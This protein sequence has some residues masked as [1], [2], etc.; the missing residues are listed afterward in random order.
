MPRQTWT[1]FAGGDI[2]LDRG[3]YDVL[4][5]K[6][7]GADFPFDGGTA[8]ITSLVCCSS[9]GWKVPTLG[10]TGEQGRDP[11]PDLGAPTSR[12]RTSRT[13]RRTVPVPHVGDDL[14]RRPDADRRHRQGR[15]RLSWAWPTT[16]S[17]TRGRPA[18]S[19]PSRTSGSAACYGR[20]RQGHRRGP[21][22]GHPRHARRQGRDPR[23]RRDRR[24]TTRTDA[25]RPGS[26]R[27]TTKVVKADIKEAR[28]AGADVVIVF[29]H[30]GAEYDATAG[31][32]GEQEPGPEGHRCR[33]PTWSSATTPTGP[34]RWRS[35]RASRSGTR[36]ATSSS[37]RPGRSSDDGRR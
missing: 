17:A 22:A 31:Q 29:P 25:D 35:T 27:L 12:S 5:N 16:T 26:A 11:R 20:R 19:R 14:L 13:R 36:S 3:V 28:A 10:R 9:F 34:P 2:M 37:T 1:L 21:Q 4:R 8:D 24:S 32:S 33:A 7:K 18:S 30:W 23:L 15:L 6:G